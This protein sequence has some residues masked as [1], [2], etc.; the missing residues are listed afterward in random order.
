M[1]DAAGRT[2]GFEY[3]GVGRRGREVNG[4]DRIVC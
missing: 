3:D 4:N 2:T 1:T